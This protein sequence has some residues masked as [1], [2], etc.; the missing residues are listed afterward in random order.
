MLLLKTRLIKLSAFIIA[1]Q[2]L[3]MSI[4]SPN[5]ANNSYTT[6]SNFNYIETYIE[7]IAEVV[8]K[9]E[10]AFP[11]SGK[12]HPKHWQQHKLYQVICENAVGI[13]NYTTFYR[14]VQNVFFNGHDKYA[15]LFIKDISPPP[16]FFC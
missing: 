1:L 7:Y 13:N 5:A 14:L 11:E 4:E 6:P 15:Y 16:K 12:N 2:I 8:F 9:H 10:N 3:N